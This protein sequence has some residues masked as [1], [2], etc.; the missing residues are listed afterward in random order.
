MKTKEEVLK[1]V[2]GIME[3]YVNP[4]V[5]A[6]GGQVNVLDFDPETGVLHTQLSGSCSGCAGSTMTLKMGIESTLMHFIPEISAVTSEDD[7]MFSNP[8]YSDS[9]FYAFDDYVDPLDDEDDWKPED[10]C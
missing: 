10:G 4:N 6:H 3:K 2:E 5:E 9:S 8:F 1:E 7:P